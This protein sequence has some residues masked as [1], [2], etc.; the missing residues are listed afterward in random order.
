MCRRPHSGHGARQPIPCH[1]LLLPIHLLLLPRDTQCRMDRR[2]T[3]RKNMAM[4]IDVSTIPG[5]HGMGLHRR[6]GDR[7]RIPP[8]RMVDRRDRNSSP[9][10]FLPF[11]PIAQ[12]NKKHL[13]SADICI[14]RLLLDISTPDVCHMGMSLRCKPYL[15]PRGNTILAIHNLDDH[16]SRSY[17][18]TFS[19]DNKKADKQK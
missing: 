6:N 14:G 18:N 19:R 1:Q 13:Q 16:P 17:T 4:G 11:G 8:T 3:Q 7:F 9:T 12:K 2:D 10:L 15:T 5:F